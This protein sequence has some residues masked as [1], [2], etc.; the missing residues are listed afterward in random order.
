[1]AQQ[2]RSDASSG[3]AS[4]TDNRSPSWDASSVDT[5][6]NTAA[7]YQT[8]PR[9]EAQP[10]SFSSE[11]NLRGAATEFTTA[12]QIIASTEVISLDSDDDDE[13]FATTKSNGKGKEKAGHLAVNGS[14][15]PSSAQSHRVSDDDDELPS[16]GSLKGPDPS[17]IGAECVR[18]AQERAK[19]SSMG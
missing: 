17:D 6:V 4:G 19:L 15:A 5:L 11:S 2:I 16:N 8:M 13:P 9:L 10:Q 1:M 3:I 7:G 18:R 12:G 14:D